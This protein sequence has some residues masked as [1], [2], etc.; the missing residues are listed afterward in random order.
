ML[1]FPRKRCSKHVPFS[2]LQSSNSNKSVPHQAGHTSPAFQ[3]YH[4]ITPSLST[5]YYGLIKG[6]TGHI[7]QQLIYLGFFCLLLSS[8]PN[9]VTTRSSKK[10]CSPRPVQNKSAWSSNHQPQDCYSRVVTQNKV[11]EKSLTEKYH[12][13]LHIPPLIKT[14]TESQWKQVTFLKSSS[15]SLVLFIIYQ[16][17]L[18]YFLF[19]GEEIK[20]QYKLCLTITQWQ[21]KR[22][23]QSL[24]SQSMN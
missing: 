8:L 12:F 16:A 2:A 9:P 23:Q 6:Y 10:A 1:G 4:S 7:L 3:T 13:H 20:Q 22:E 24:Q 19:K 18:D 17:N 14:H 21:K 11:T 5:N 15:P